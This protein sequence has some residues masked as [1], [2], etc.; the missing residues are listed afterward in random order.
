MFHVKQGGNMKWIV[1]YHV[2]FSFKHARMANKNNEVMKFDSQ[3]E[4]V[5]YLCELGQ[6]PDEVMIIPEMEFLN[7]RL[8]D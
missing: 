4:A 2:E 8:Y 5:D 6:D 3:G 1:S 7:G